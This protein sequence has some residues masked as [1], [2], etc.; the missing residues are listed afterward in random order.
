[1]GTASSQVLTRFSHGIDNATD[2]IDNL[3]QTI[4]GL[5]ND[6]KDLQER[7]RYRESI[8]MRMM[9][10]NQRCCKETSM[11][12]LGAFRRIELKINSAQETEESNHKHIEQALASMESRIEQRLKSF[13]PLATHSSQQTQWQWQRTSTSRKR[14]ADVHDEYD[15]AEADIKVAAET[16]LAKRH[17]AQPS[18]D[19]R[20][21]IDNA[22][23]Y[24][25]EFVP[26]QH[27]SGNPSTH[28]DV[29]SSIRFPENLTREGD[30]AD[31]ED[32]ASPEGHLGTSPPLEAHAEEE[33]DDYGEEFSLEDND[34][35]DEEEEIVDASVSSESTGEPPAP[36]SGSTLRHSLRLRRHGPQ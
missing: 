7:F 8:L 16:H 31:T 1:M 30:Q 20:E 32:A 2:A 3:R 5:S 12:A 29:S 27:P 11:A 23:S 25:L 33:Y 9:E 6:I 18:V 35:D 19:S 34:A 24:S 10:D 21:A 28:S 17:S 36:Q 4:N 14:G 26:H 22:S 13:V 15:E